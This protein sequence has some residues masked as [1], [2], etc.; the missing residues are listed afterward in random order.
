MTVES[1]SRTFNPQLLKCILSAVALEL[2][3]SAKRIIVTVQI[4][5]AFSVCTTTKSDPPQCPPFTSFYT[6]L[7]KKSLSTVYSVGY[8]YRIEKKPW[9]WASFLLSPSWVLWAGLQNSSV[10]RGTVSAAASA[11]RDAHQSSFALSLL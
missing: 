8:R 2:G 4:I 11:L 1:V 6:S 7:A 5:V 9:L 3:T 10:E